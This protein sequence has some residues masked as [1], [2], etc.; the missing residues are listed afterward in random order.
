MTYRQ[1]LVARDGLAPFNYQCD[2]E[3][4]SHTNNKYVLN[5]GYDQLVDWILR[6]R[7]PSVAQPIV[8]TTVSPTLSLAMRMGLFL[9]V[10]GLRRSRYPQQPM[11]E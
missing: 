1:G 7:P 11:T 10:S 6:N 5:A 9:A 8:V 4:L 3:P 2:K